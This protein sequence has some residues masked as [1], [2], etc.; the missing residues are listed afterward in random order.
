MIQDGLIGAGNSST[1]VFDAIIKSA[2]RGA[3]KRH[4]RTPVPSHAT[5]QQEVKI[6]GGFAGIPPRIDRA[7]RQGPRFAQT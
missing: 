1:S 3:F 2:I 7:G 6:P 5:P 4:N